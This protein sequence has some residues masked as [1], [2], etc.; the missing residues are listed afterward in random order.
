[1]D[2][3]KILIVN[4]SKGR[5]G[6]EPAHLSGALL[7]RKEQWEARFAERAAFR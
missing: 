6:A 1:M 2:D 4:L 5:M 3:R 7:V